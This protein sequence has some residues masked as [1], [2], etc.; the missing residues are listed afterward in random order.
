MDLQAFF[1]LS[2]LIGTLGWLGHAISRLMNHLSQATGRVQA[3]RQKCSRDAEALLRNLQEIDRLNAEMK[4]NRGLIDTT[5]Q[6]LAKRR[7][8]VEAFVPP[9]PPSIYATAEFPASKRD[10]GWVIRSKMTGVSATK[11]PAGA[12]EKYLLIWAVDYA[13]AF[14]R[15]RQ[16]LGRQGF[17]PMAGH[18]LGG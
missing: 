18:R 8:E 17:E 3:V 6:A 12:S 16:I 13:L 14:A 4:E 1:L 11:L 15:A 2:V 7:Q 5:V 10:H 9:P